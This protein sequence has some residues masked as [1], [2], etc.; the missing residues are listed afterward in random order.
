MAIRKP[1]FI[2]K[3]IRG[4]RPVATRPY[5]WAPGIP[6]LAIEFI[7]KPGESLPKPE[8]VDIGDVLGTQNSFAITTQDDLMIGITPA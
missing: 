7:E 5:K 1:A 2:T 8:L 6:S 3:Q 4:G